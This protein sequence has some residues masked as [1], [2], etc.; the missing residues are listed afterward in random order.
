M[1]YP[2]LLTPATTEPITLPSGRVVH[3]PKAEPVFI[4]WSGEPLT[5][6]YG[7]KLVL[8]LDGKPAFAELVILRLLQQD[9][10]S[11]VWVDTYQHKYRTE[12]WP[13]NNVA[14]P[15]AQQQLLQSIYQQAGSTKGCFDVLCWRGQEHLFAES[16][17]HRHDKIRDTQRQWLQAALDCGMPLTSF[18]V[19]EWALRGERHRE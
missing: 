18:L 17:R 6:T 3:V 14:L 7:G 1:R 13:K 10:W 9:G 8:E 15:S 16:K 12:Y 11:G 19:V 4:V 2:S 5:D